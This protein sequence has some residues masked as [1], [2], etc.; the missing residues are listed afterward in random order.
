MGGRKGKVSG[1]YHK[2]IRLTVHSKGMLD[3]MFCELLKGFR[4]GTQAT[5]HLWL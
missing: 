4:G 5:L 1:P 3:F 2:I